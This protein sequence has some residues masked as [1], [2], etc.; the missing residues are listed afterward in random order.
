MKCRINI[1][2]KELF[3]ETSI[4]LISAI[5]FITILLMER[6]R[7]ESNDLPHEGYR[8]VSDS[9]LA[10]SRG[11]KEDALRKKLL[12]C[13]WKPN[14]IDKAR[15]YL[16][17]PWNKEAIEYFWWYVTPGCDNGKAF[18]NGISQNSMLPSVFNLLVY[19]HTNYEDQELRGIIADLFDSMFINLRKNP[20]KYYLYL[21]FFLCKAIE[22]YGTPDLLGPGFWAGL[23]PEEGDLSHL[24]LLGNIGDE[25]IL[26]KLKSMQNLVNDEAARERIKKADEEA[27]KNGGKRIILMEDPSAELSRTIEKIE[28]RLNGIPEISDLDKFLILIKSGQKKSHSIHQERKTEDKEGKKPQ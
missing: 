25:E 14:K 6:C 27:A 7:A 23:K 4:V 28:N 15:S 21:D 12:G 19:V 8:E 5:S 24:D 13:F 26:K 10:E 1:N 18:E 20:N 22:S 3:Y 16:N 17:N 9:E 2:A 11:E